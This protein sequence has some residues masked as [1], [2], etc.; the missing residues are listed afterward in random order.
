MTDISELI[1]GYIH[2]GKQFAPDTQSAE[3]TYGWWKLS[4]GH[5]R[6]EFNESV[7]LPER[8]RVLILHPWPDAVRAGVNHPS[9]VI[10]ESRDTLFTHIGVGPQGIAVKENARLGK[11]T[12]LA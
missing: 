4:Q 6:I 5:Y 7:T 9:E 10:T 2:E 12:I 11:V 1:G 3:D 8:G